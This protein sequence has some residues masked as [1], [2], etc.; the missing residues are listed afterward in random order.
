MSDDTST[1]EVWIGV[2][3]AAAPLGIV[4]GALTLPALTRRA[5]AARSPSD[6]PLPHLVSA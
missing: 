6:I 4:K 1:L 2:I 3:G 5:M